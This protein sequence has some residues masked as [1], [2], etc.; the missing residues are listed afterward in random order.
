MAE[1]IT[2]WSL[3]NDEYFKTYSPIPDNYNLK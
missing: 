2:Q 1:V 3:I